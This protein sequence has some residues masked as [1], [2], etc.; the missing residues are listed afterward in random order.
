MQINYNIAQTHMHKHIA[1]YISTIIIC[2][3]CA[4]MMFVAV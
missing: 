1:V 3:M 2:I 4:Q